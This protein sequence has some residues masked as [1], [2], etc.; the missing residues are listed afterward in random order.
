MPTPVRPAPPPRC[1]GGQ[2]CLLLPLTTAAQNAIITQLRP[3]ILR[4]PGA[5]LPGGRRVHPGLE[6]SVVGCLADY[7]VTWCCRTVCAAGPTAEPGLRLDGQRAAGAGLRA[8]PGDSPVTFFIGDYWGRHYRHQP[9]FDEY[10]WRPP[11][12][13]RFIPPPH[14]H[15]GRWWRPYLPR[16]VQPGIQPP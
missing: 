9:W 16:W 12:P 8:V 11:P 7:V 5:G 2:R 1:S 14:H 6:V 3:Q 10:R 15:D 4:R 13:P